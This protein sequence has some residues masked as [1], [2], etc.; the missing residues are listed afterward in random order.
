M[1]VVGCAAIEGCDKMLTRIEADT[2]IAM[3]KHFRN[4]H[5]ISLPPGIDETHELI[6]ADQRERFLL[7]LW[8]G[9][10]RLSKYKLQTRGRMIVVLVRLDIN[11]AP[12][13]NPD[14]QKLDGTHIH[15]YREGF[16]DK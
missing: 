12:H 8:R 5:T 10:M 4:L 2:L 13:T 14:G 9:T 16:E 3:R 15:F 7:D 6:G 11:G 1:H